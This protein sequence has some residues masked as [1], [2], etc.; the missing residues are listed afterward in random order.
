MLGVSV[1]P[2]VSVIVADGAVV[3][4]GV[5]VSVGVEVALGIGVNV[6]GSEG[7]GV[8]VGVWVGRINGVGNAPTFCGVIGGPANRPTTR[9]MAP[10]V[11][12]RNTR[13]ITLKTRAVPVPMKNPRM[14]MTGRDTIHRVH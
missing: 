12:S 2:A 11:S 10:R 7:V 8:I 6:G 3:G 9:I 1:G 5:P 14:P 13:L 4:S